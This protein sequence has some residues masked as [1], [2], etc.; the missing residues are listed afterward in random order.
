ME[1][2]TPA[3]LSSV[4]SWVVLWE[5]VACNLTPSLYN[6]PRMPRTPEQPPNIEIVEMPFL[7]SSRFD[8]R[9]TSQS[10]YDTIQAIVRDRQ[11]IA[12]FSVFR[13]LQNWPESM[14]KAPPSQKRWYVAVIGNPPPE[15]FL[16]QV[17][18]AI[19]MGEPVPIPDEVTEML[20]QRRMEQMA[21]RPYSEIHRTFTVPRK[22][23]RNK[24]KMKRTMQKN[25]RRRNR[26]K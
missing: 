3:S 15:P 23:E 7:L 24:E 14:S 19:Q 25:S 8:S 16:T 5:C 21:K 1:S 20:V 22:G 13:L 11:D 10:P 12:D 18:E 6:D 26:G 9:E 2:P 4:S 17:R